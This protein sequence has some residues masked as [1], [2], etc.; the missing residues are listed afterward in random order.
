MV[1]LH[2]YE[3][4]YYNSLVGGTPNAFRQ[5]EMDYWGTSFRDAMGYINQNAP[6]DARVIVWGPVTTAWAYARPDL[7][8][9]SNEEPEVEHGT[10]F[11]LLSSRY[12]ND[13]RVY[14]DAPVLYRVEQAGVTLA[15]V[16]MI[17]KPYP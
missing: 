8:V 16:K 15:V 11:A 17:E 5:Y 4:I 10:F 7:E 9:I 1:Q 12:D 3:Y 6:A 14:P 13:L 2:P